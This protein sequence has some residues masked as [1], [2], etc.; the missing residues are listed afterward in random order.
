M[1]KALA[2]YMWSRQQLYVL[3]IQKTTAKT[4]N[5]HSNTHTHTHAQTYANLG[6]QTP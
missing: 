4:G 2:L 5:H 1:K 6:S 3:K